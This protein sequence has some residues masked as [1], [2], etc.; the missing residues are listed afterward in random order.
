M[1]RGPKRPVTVHTIAEHV[2]VSAAAVSTV[3]AN[4]HVER[5]LAPETV[6]R[7]RKAVQELGYVPNMA[8]RRLRVQSSA[9]RQIDLAI[10]TSFEAPLPLVSQVL[11]ALQQAVDAQTSSHT[12]YAVSIEMFHA[13][14]LQ[15]KPGLLDAHRY[16]GVILTNTLADDDDFLARARLPYPVVVIGRRIPTCCCVLETPGFVGQRSAEVLLD[17]GCRQPAVLHG[18][19]LTQATAERVTAFR[20][21]VMARLGREPTVLESERLQP[22]AAS[23][24]LQGYFAGGGRCDGLFTVTD[25]LAVGAYHAI[26]RSGRKIPDD[27][28]V[29]GVGDFELAEFF[30]PPLSTVAGANEAM[31]AEAVP[32]LFRL[33]RGEKNVPQEV[34]VVPPVYLR[35]STQRLKRPRKEA[36]S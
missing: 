32:L 6:E 35:A 21:A 18:R 26:Q 31:V 1:A 20:R 3:L 29:V 2:G 23:A 5:R 36:G 7:I 30:T 11:H 12:R 33:L 13:G 17:A 16:H 10:L 28:A 25:S 8:G 4:R 22:A 24:A 19:L 15:E 34:L 27:V 14:H 9:T